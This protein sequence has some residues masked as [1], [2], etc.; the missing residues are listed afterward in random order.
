MRTLCRFSRE[1]LRSRG[2]LRSLFSVG[3]ILSVVDKIAPFKVLRINNNIQ[4]WF[5]DEAAKA[6]K[7]VIHLVRT[8]NF[9]NN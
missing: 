8:K 4:D 9:L 1:N 2:K 5:D 6:I 7:G 3:K